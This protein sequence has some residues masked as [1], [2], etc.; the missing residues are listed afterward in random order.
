MPWSKQTNADSPTTKEK[1]PRQI[2]YT[3]APV[4]TTLKKLMVIGSIHF[5]SEKCHQQFSTFR[6]DL[7]LALHQM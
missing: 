6:E 4:R 2:V 7:V 5:G 3:V 1:I